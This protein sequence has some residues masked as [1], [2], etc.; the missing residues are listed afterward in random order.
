MYIR[1]KTLL[2][3]KVEVI[4][5]WPLKCVFFLHLD[6]MYD[7]N[8]LTI[9]GNIDVRITAY[10]GDI[11]QA[12]PVLSIFTKVQWDQTDRSQVIGADQRR[13]IT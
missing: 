1:E 7:Y 12:R 11:F 8:M 4:K 2:F 9:W 5:A 6:K 13:S 10:K 3:G